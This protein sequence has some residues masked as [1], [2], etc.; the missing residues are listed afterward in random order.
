MPL[1][2]KVNKIDKLLRL[3]KKKKKG[4]KLLISEM[5]GNIT[6]NGIKIF[7][8]NQNEIWR[9]ENLFLVSITKSYDLTF[10]WIR[11]PAVKTHRLKL[12]IH[13]FC[14]R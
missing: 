11:V 2:W 14:H 9:V 3:T 12:I 1:P 6:S 10:I 7:C 4:D 5:K 8:K 13:T